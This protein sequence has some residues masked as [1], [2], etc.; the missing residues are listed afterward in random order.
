[1]SWT[2]VSSCWISLQLSRFE[3][4]V[5]QCTNH[6]FFVNKIRPC[7]YACSVDVQ[8]SM[9]F[10]LASANFRLQANRLFLQSQN[11]VVTLIGVCQNHW[12][13]YTFNFTFQPTDSSFWT[14]N[15]SLHLSQSQPCKMIPTSWTSATEQPRNKHPNKMWI[16]KLL[17]T[18][19]GIGSWLW[20]GCWRSQG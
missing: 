8:S 4:A 13:R 1:M 7:S 5:G 10:C 14:L 12:L 2:L 17:A 15:Q 20:T 18:G 6:P 3:N 19:T 9:H 16:D 11:G